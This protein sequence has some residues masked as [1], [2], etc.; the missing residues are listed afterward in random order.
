[1]RVI[2]PNSEQI[3]VLPIGDALKRA[4]EAG[5]D[6][7]EIAPTAAPP[8]CRIIDYGK[9]RY[10]QAKKQHGAKQKSTQLK[11]VKLRPFTDT[12]DLDFKTRHARDF[13]A[14]GHKV[15]MTVMFRGREMAHQDAGRTVLAKVIEQLGTAAQVEQQ[16]RMEGRNMSILLAP[17]HGAG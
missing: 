13:L 2:G 5:M 15:K 4:E 7:V 6:L 3:G 11:E 1:V 12:H 16:P 14:E 10:E 9:Y 17:K 8:V